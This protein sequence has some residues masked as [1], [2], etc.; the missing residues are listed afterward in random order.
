VKH[1]P[2]F[3]PSG[4]A[5]DP[6]GK[7]VNSP[8]ELTAHTVEPSV[9]PSGEV[10]HFESVRL[11]PAALRPILLICAISCLLEALWFNDVPWKF[12]YALE[13]SL[14]C[15]QSLEETSVSFYTIM[16]SHLLVHV[17]SSLFCLL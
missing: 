3:E 6:V 10:L 7:V 12:Y 13:S 2:W 15:Q 17:E 11:S 5:D 8:A 14:C 9:K 1:P 4:A 16:L